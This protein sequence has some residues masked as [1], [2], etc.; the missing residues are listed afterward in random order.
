M[1]MIILRKGCGMKIV[2]RAA[3]VILV[4]ERGTL[5]GGKN[6]LMSQIQIQ[7]KLRK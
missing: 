3:G 4:V 7:I 2:P 1:V 6:G 5:G